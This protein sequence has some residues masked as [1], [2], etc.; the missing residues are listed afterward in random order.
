[1]RVKATLLILVACAM[2][3][4]SAFSATTTIPV[5]GNASQLLLTADRD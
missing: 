3:A 5:K 2:A 4:G 1:M